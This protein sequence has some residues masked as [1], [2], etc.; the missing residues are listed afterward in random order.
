LVLQV[1]PLQQFCPSWPQ[2]EHLP[3]TES[4]DR[5]V[6]HL[7]LVLQQIWP[8]APHSGRQTPLGLHIRPVLQRGG[9][10]QHIC[11]RSPHGVG[12]R[13]VPLAQVRPDWH[14]GWVAQHIAPWVPQLGGGGWQVPFAAQT[15]PVK[16]GE[17]KPQQA[18]PCAP[19]SR[20]AQAPLMHSPSLQTLPAQ[21]AKP[22][23]P[24]PPIGGRMSS[25]SLIGAGGAGLGLAGTA[26]AFGGA[27]AGLSAA[28]GLS[29]VAGFVSLA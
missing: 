14:C 20:S 21:Q 13:Q 24:Q 10:A 27:V 19:Q 2:A 18:D 25:F 3:V 6:A 29:A 4:Q 23:C 5:P 1:V 9:P 22:S 7:G 26:L 17:G 12:A 15:S 16:Q 28:A 8:L 11:P